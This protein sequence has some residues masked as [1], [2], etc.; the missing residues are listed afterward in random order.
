M[1]PCF[2]I[3][4]YLFIQV[5]IHSMLCIYL[6]YLYTMLYLTYYFHKY[7]EYFSLF[8]K[9][10]PNPEPRSHKPKRNYIIQA[11]PSIYYKDIKTTFGYVIQF[12]GLFMFIYH[13]L[14]IQNRYLRPIKCERQ[15]LC[16]ARKSPWQ[17]S[18]IYQWLFNFCEWDDHYGYKHWS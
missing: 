6:C 15:A 11:K 16:N 13:P 5:N 3:K 17:W 8:V 14:Y 12:D 2:V 10:S 7:S 18:L 1:L 9:F 4:P